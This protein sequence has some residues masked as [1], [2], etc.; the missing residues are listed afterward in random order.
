LPGK[1][2][3]Q[4]KI[5]LDLGCGDIVIKRNGEEISKEKYES[6][7]KYIKESDL[8]EVTEEEDNTKLKE[9]VACGGAGCEVA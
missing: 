1:D 5:I 9:S 3:L 8:S 7:L 4:N 2:E 6:M